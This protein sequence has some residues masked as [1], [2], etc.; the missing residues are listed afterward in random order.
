MLLGNISSFFKEAE[1]ASWI[2]TTYLLTMCCT[3]PLYGRFCDMFGCKRSVLLALSIFSIGTI[4]CGVARS[5]N[6]ILLAR[7]VA[8]LGGGGLGTVPSVIFSHII[9]IKSRGLYQG[10]GNIFSCLGMATGAPLG[11]L[12]NDTIGWRGA[13]LIQIP[14][15]L[16]ALMALY[17]F[18]EHDESLHFTDDQSL[19]QRLRD[20]DL[21][22]WFIYTLTPILSLYTL[23]LVSG[24][25]YAL[26]DLRV[27]LGM[28]S[29]LFVALLFYIVE[30]R[31]IKMPLLSLDVMRLRSGWSTMFAMIWLNV[32]MVAYSF[33]FPL[34]FQTVGKLTPSVIGLRMVPSSIAIGL[35][36]LFAGFYMRRTGRYYKL[37]LVCHFAM[38]LASIPTATYLLDPPPF[39]PFVYYTILTF[40]HGVFFTTTLIALIHAV[41]KK[42]FG[43]ATGMNYLFRTTGQV[44]GV[45]ASGCIVQYFL[46]KEL[47]NRIIGPGS[48]ELIHEI[49]QDIR[50][51]PTLPDGIR[52]QAMESYATALHCVFVFVTLVYLLSLINCYFI[53]DK[54]LDEDHGITEE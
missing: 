34:Y 32:G 26:T 35:G 27:L 3:A 25:G 24:Q 17:I 8:G 21:L 13:F 36:S 11:G 9:P 28:G 29:V 44:L 18:L 12:L 4:G 16:L 1:K 52:E 39:S 46:T 23:D 6:E 47:Q 50:V 43:V 7:A 53:E 41:N 45:A 33:N 30:H 19:S 10:I 14:V 51:L 54:H 15:L 5:M 20:L 31:K 49:R 22:G 48:E 40:T 37:T 2:G 42:Y 38:V